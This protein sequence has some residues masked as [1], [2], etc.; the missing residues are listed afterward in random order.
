MTHEPSHSLHVF[1]VHSSIPLGSPF[2]CRQGISHRRMWWKENESKK[3]IIMNT[4]YSPN[5][6]INRILRMRRSVWTH[7]QNGEQGIYP[8]IELVWASSMQRV[9]FHY[10]ISQIVDSSHARLL[11]LL[12]FIILAMNTRHSQS[13]EWELLAVLRVHQ[14]PQCFVWFIFLSVSFSFS[15]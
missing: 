4:S 13:S 2:G 5:K 8:S 15:I 14:S 9:R 12:L 10:F 3:L 11:C 7:R 6:Y 1:N